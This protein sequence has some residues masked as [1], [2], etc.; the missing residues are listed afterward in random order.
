MHGAC[1]Q[2]KDQRFSWTVLLALL[3][4][5][6]GRLVLRPLNKIGQISCTTERSESEVL[7]WSP[8]HNRFISEILVSTNFLDAS[9]STMSRRRRNS[10]S[11]LLDSRETSFVSHV[12]NNRCWGAVCCKC[13]E[14]LSI[15]FSSAIWPL[16]GHKMPDPGSTTYGIPSRNKSITLSSS[17]LF[18][19]HN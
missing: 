15:N 10:L 8:I 13:W 1:D 4:G 7:R 11:L 2:I 14:V 16:P 5:A 17:L 19:F 9:P 18:N 12:G 3:T 6:W